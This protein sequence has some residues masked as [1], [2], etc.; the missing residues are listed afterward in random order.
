MD[1][2]SPWRVFSRITL[3]LLMPNLVCVVL[4]LI[5][6][7]SRPSTKSSCD[8]WRARLGDEF[9]VSSS[10]RP[11]REQIRCT[12]WARPRSSCSRRRSSC[13]AAAASRDPRRA[14]RHTRPRVNTPVDPHTH[15]L[16]RRA[17]TDAWTGPTVHYGYLHWLG[18]DVRSRPVA[19]AV[20]VQDAGRA[21]RVP[22]DAVPYGQTTVVVAAKRRRV[23]CS[24]ASP[25]AR[26]AK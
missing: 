24:G 15:L 13:D 16:T 26:R 10:I 12:P 14:R 2:A 7:G 3:P 19:R 11:V 18:P 22:A 1:H 17:A 25:T 21:A 4:A 5:R 9:I 8:G 23:R 20:V 6:A